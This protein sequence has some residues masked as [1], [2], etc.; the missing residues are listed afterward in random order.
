MGSYARRV[1]GRLV[2]LQPFGVDDA[3]PL[4][5][6]PIHVNARVRMTLAED[7]NTVS[8]TSWDYLRCGFGFGVGVSIVML[9]D[10][11]GA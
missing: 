4:H 5:L 7:L 9:G 6:R 11:W 10:A 8:R 1:D 3:H 2:Q